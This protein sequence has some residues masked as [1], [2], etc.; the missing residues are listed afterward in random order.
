MNNS[1]L[2]EFSISI[3]DHDT[4]DDTYMR[5]ASAVYTVYTV[6]PEN[7]AEFNLRDSRV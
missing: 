5:G 4:I 2:S 1:P 3:H 6:L 7:L